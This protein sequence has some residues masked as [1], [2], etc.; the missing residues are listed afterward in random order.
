MAKTLLGNPVPEGVD[1]PKPLP[2]ETKKHI[3]DAKWKLTIDVATSPKFNFTEHE[4]D[5][6]HSAWLEV[7]RMRGTVEADRA[8]KNITTIT[9]ADNGTAVDPFIAGYL[10]DWGMTEWSPNMPADLRPAFK[11]YRDEIDCIA[12][13]LKAKGVVWIDEYREWYRLDKEQNAYVKMLNQQEAVQMAMD[14]IR[15]Q[16]EI[17]YNY[18]EVSAD[19]DFMKLMQ[20]MHGPKANVENP[21][22]SALNVNV[23]QFERQ[24]YYELC[25]PAGKYDL[26]TGKLISKDN[27]MT[28]TVTE[29]APDFDEGRWNRSMFKKVL[30]TS[31]DDPDKRDYLQRAIGFSLYGLLTDGGQDPLLH[32]WCGP[33]GAGKSSI[34]N[35]INAA[36]GSYAATSIDV[37]VFTTASGDMHKQH[38]KAQLFGKRFVLTNE[39]DDNTWL[40]GDTLKGVVSK[41]PIEA[42]EKYK[43]SFEFQNNCSVHMLTNNLP[44]IK[45]VED[46]AVRT[47]IRVCN[48]EHSFVDENRVPLKGNRLKKI[49][50]AI[51][52]EHP[53]ILAWAIRGAVK[54]AK[55][56][57][58]L[59]PPAVIS[60][61]TNAYFATYDWINEF[62]QSEC[63]MN[64]STKDSMVPLSSL[65]I[66]F[67]KWGEL[68]G[69]RF[70]SMNNVQFSKR[71]RAKYKDSH[72]LLIKRVGKTCQNCVIGLALRSGTDAAKALDKQI[73]G[74][75]GF[76]PNREADKEEKAEIAKA[77]ET[78]KPAPA[79]PQGDPLAQFD[80][81][82][83]GD[84]VDRLVPE[85]RQEEIGVQ[86]AKLDT[87]ERSVRSAVERRLPEA[88][89]RIREL[90]ATPSSAPLSPDDEALLYLA[91]AAA[92]AIKEKVQNA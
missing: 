13:E 79:K 56:G 87:P 37:K 3:D 78:E 90:I 47:R 15:R 34:F 59:I 38:E 67:Q 32:I 35:P 82:R 71:L 88:L 22:R 10:K 84:A 29:V 52:K 89:G 12:R 49:E 91:W 92:D 72:D 33:H 57:F 50:G 55:D 36:L 9:Y 76:N 86:A 46:S 69:N 14:F 25:T 7:F 80:C 44:Q 43:K 61:E 4:I 53:L 17:A 85:K 30:E 20:T 77:R 6:L 63:D 70:Y 65:F 60:K 8:V 83:L 48:F 54:F 11:T 66:R 51:A 81:A 42:E 68:T 2:E 74:F 73:Y 24:A 31:L 75:E 40:A 26:R 58:Y 18:P 16:D 19:A 41:D 21:L 27:G 28:M 62:I 39:L 1:E 23:A 45:N 64:A 5:M